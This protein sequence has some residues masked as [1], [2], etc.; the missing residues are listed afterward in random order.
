VLAT[1]DRVWTDIATKFLEHF[2]Y[3]AHA[4]S[5]G[6]HPLWDDEDGFYYDHIRQSDG[7]SLALKVRTVVGLLPL[8]ATTL[9]SSV[10]LIRLP[11][12]SAR[13]RWFLT[14]RPEF[15]HVLGER[16]LSEGGQQQRLI[17]AVGPR[18][19]RRVLSRM[20][21]EGEFLSPYGLRT[22]SKAHL[23]HPFSVQLGDH[24][25][26]IGYEP[27]E[28]RSGTFGGNSNWRGPIWFPV[29]YLLVE[30]L[31]SYARFYHDVQIEYPTGSGKKLTFPQ[32]ADDIS[33]RLVS[34]FLK[35]GNGNR[36]M[37]PANLPDDWKDLIVFPEYFHGDTGEGLGAMHQAG[38][39]G[40]VLDLI[41]AKGHRRQGN[42]IQGF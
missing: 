16:R 39:T 33:D 12:I 11:E 36:P 27:A 19:L 28:S 41:L 25:F 32:I 26:S 37:W 21:D 14:E 31:R 22:L 29:N 1:K 23:E 17:S 30:S 13:L 4:A 20:L 34:L 6:D 3:I 24:E 15:T 42:F 10:T 2:A 7:K 8:C 5:E 9:L 38:W 35:D 40:L 18:K